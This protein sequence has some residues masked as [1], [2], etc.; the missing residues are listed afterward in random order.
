MTAAEQFSIG[1]MVRLRSCAFGEP[2]TVLR[3]EQR[4]VIVLW[5]DLD[6]LARHSPESLM[7]SGELPAPCTVR[8]L[9]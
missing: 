4:K 6:Y 8:R 1:A 7:L 3:I 5:R 9:V 2:G